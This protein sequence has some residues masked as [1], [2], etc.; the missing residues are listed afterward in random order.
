VVVEG[1]VWAVA[2]FAAVAFDLF[3]TLATEFLPDWRPGP[4][5]AERLGVPQQCYAELWR[6]RKHE[7]MTGTVD[8]RDVLRQMCT[9][10][11][12]VIDRQVEE[13]IETL[14]AERL[15]AKARPLQQVDDRL[16]QAL[17]Q[18]RARGLRLAVIS[19]CSGEEVMGWEA[20]PL[21]PMFDED[22]GGTAPCARW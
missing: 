16:L 22:S 13:T 9:A 2:R 18:L 3:E 8:Y 11:D 4:S 14:Y 12:V 5:T 7:R 20:S 19:N 1:K 17:D 21:A 15:A 6:A 10:A